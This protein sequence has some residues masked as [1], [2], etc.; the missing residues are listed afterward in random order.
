M[1]QTLNNATRAI[2]PD[3]EWRVAGTSDDPHLRFASKNG[4]VLLD[5]KIHDALKKSFEDA[6]FSGSHNI[7]DL[8]APTSKYGSGNTSLRGFALRGHN[9]IMS[10]LPRLAQTDWIKPFTESLKSNVDQLKAETV[11]RTAVRAH[12]EEIK[13]APIDHTPNPAERALEKIAKDIKTEIGTLPQDAQEK[14]LEKLGKILGKGLMKVLPITAL[15]IAAHERM[16]LEEASAA[17]VQK[18]ILTQDD[19]D[20]YKAGVLESSVGL[21]TVDPTIGIAE[22]VAHL[23]YRTWLGG[24]SPEKREAVGEKLAPPSVI[25]DGFAAIKDVVTGWAGPG[26]NTGAMSSYNGLVQT[27]SAL[28]KNVS[29]E[30]K[31]AAADIAGDTKPAPEVKPGNDFKM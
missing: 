2:F 25:K 18:G 5:P 4:E 28:D 19:A 7:N 11:K 20:R 8:V 16:G 26:D 24:L 29:P 30:F 31:T 23:R 15:G 6:G 17:L 10:A 21:E 13:A 22:G 12:I 27:P 3:H 14:V 9:E 1:R